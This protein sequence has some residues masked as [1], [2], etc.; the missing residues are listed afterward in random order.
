M[1]FGRIIGNVTVYNQEDIKYWNERL[2]NIPLHISHQIKILSTHKKKAFDYEPRLNRISD[3]I[4][5][6]DAKIHSIEA[7]IKFLKNESGLQSWRKALQVEA[8]KLNSLEHESLY[9]TFQIELLDKHIIQTNRLVSIKRIHDIQKDLEKKIFEHKNMPV[10]QSKLQ[11]ESERLKK[12]LFTHFSET[13]IKLSFSGSLQAFETQVS[14]YENEKKQLQSKQHNF[15]LAI[16]KHHNAIKRAQEEITEYEH[17]LHTLTEKA[18]GYSRKRDVTELKKEL[19]RIKKRKDPLLAIKNKLNAGIKHH[20]QEKSAARERMALLGRELQSHRSN[21][22]LINLRDNPE[23]LLDQLAQAIQV[24]LEKY[25]KTHPANQS[26]IV[27]TCLLEL[28]RNTSAQ[29]ILKAASLNKDETRKKYYQLCGLIWKMLKRAN[30]PQNL[31]FCRQLLA[32]FQS[33]SP[34]P[35]E[36]IAAYEALQQSNPR[37]FLE[38]TKLELDDFE[39]NEYKAAQKKLHLALRPKNTLMHAPIEIQQLHKKAADIAKTIRAEKLIPNNPE[40]DIKYATFA[41]NATTELLQD[42]PNTDLQK[43]Y[44][45]LI[46]QNKK[47]QPSTCKKIAGALLAFLGAALLAASVVAK[48]LT[49]GVASPLT[50]TGM[51]LGSTLIV[52]GVG[53]FCQ[54]MRKGLSKD[55]KQFGEHAEHAALNQEMLGMFY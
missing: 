31:E 45:R 35:E 33:K 18:R 48:I 43:K 5:P 41:L 46:D 39:Y 37:H 30:Y 34:A 36:C 52:S 17:S 20:T 44:E 49:L 4:K 55:M 21:D 7:Q 9:L 32:T 29:Y 23:T 47:E 13:E 54:G 11:Q 26:E 8:S 1:S 28:K 15:E 14:Q 12:K 53:L 50:I 27:R 40:F 19:E 2:R 16:E 51:A 24:E 3:H 6:I 10:H 22:F 38:I 25:D 42:F